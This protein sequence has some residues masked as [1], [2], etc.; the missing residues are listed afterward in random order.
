MDRVVTAQIDVLQ[1]ERG[2]ELPGKCLIRQET[3]ADKVARLGALLEVRIAVRIE[4]DLSS[5]G[6]GEINVNPAFGKVPVRM[7][8]FRQPECGVRTADDKQYF[9]FFPPCYL[10]ASLVNG[11]QD[12]DTRLALALIDA[13]TGN[14]ERARK[15]S[16][17]ISRE[18]PLDTLTQNY[19]LPV[20]RAAIQL[21]QNDPAG[22][23]ESLERAREY[24]AASPNPFNSFY[25]AYLRGLAY[26]Q[27]NNGRLA[28]PEFHKLL[29]HPWV[30][31]RFVT[32][33]LAQLQLARAQAIAG[34]TVAARESYQDFLRLWQNADAN[35]PI[36]VQAKTDYAKLKPTGQ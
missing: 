18:F 5:L 35:V 1:L 33:S 27:M 9:H 26:L 6:A 30:V 17:A 25:P 19:S 36:L 21:R 24:D 29:D 4:H 3:L 22:A 31:G 2:V 11:P 28:E 10:A 12:R 8:H 15:I 23:I 7:G 14:I 16:D 20:I 34:D 32:G 13:R